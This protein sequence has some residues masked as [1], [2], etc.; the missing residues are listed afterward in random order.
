MP[1]GHPSWDAVADTL[2]A[3]C[4]SDKA[5]HKAAKDAKAKANTTAKGEKNGNGGARV[6]LCQNREGAWPAPC[7]GGHV[8][9]Q[10]PGH[11]TGR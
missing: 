5:W 1:D 3:E 8:L 9:K 6:G 2:F 10:N 7:A 11:G 4:K